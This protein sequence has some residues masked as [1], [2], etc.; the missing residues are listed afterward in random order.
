MKIWI[1]RDT[2]SSIQFGGLERLWVWFVKPE[3]LIKVLSE[4]DRDT[5]F[6]F[7]GEDEGHY[8]KLGWYDT[9]QKFGVRNMSFGNWLGYGEGPNGEIPICMEKIKRTFSQC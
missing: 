8:S 4:K 3:F 6:G 2:A 5:P 1:T 9:N 7:I